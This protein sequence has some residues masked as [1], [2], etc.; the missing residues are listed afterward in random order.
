MQLIHPAWRPALSGGLDPEGRILLARRLSA[1]PIF[2]WSALVLGSTATSITGSGNSIRSR[3]IGAFAA[4]S[5]S[6]VVVSLRPTIAPMSP[7]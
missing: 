2:S 7:A 5:V 6:P 3:M 4:H 1:T